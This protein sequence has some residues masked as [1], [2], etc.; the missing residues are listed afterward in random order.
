MWKAF[1]SATQDV[2]GI[3]AIWTQ[4]HQ[5]VRFSFEAQHTL[6][7][8]RTFSLCA[9]QLPG[10]RRPNSHFDSPPH[11]VDSIAAVH[12]EAGADGGTAGAPFQWD[13]ERMLNLITFWLSARLP[14]S[15]SATLSFSPV[16]PC[17]PP[18]SLLYNS[19]KMLLDTAAMYRLC[20]RFSGQMMGVCT[21]N[22]ICGPELLWLGKNLKKAGTFDD[23]AQRKN[24]Q[25]WSKWA[26]VADRHQGS[27][28]FL[29]KEE[30]LH[31]RSLGHWCWRWQNVLWT[32]ERLNQ[33]E[34]TSS[35]TTQN[36]GPESLWKHPNHKGRR[37]KR[38][39]SCSA[40]SGPAPP[41]ATWIPKW[42][43]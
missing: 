23:N 8:L 21:V 24:V 42:I 39:R 3:H 17:L 28:V 43:T 26:C 31:P 6:L 13:V 20:F 1:I 32:D 35:S 19:I 33:L 4:H 16:M 40:A 22:E 18:F 30:S 15:S 41:R 36:G 10:P 27:H 9:A 2:L 11:P 34:R 37:R 38:H 12:R 29:K 14:W 5:R 25:Q 7:D